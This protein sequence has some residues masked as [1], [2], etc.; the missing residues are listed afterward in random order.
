MAD[1]AEKPGASQLRH[2]FVIVRPNCLNPDEYSMPAY[3]S[4]V[5]EWRRRVALAELRTGTHW[6]LESMDRLNGRA[7]QPADQ[8]FCPH[9]AAVGLPGRVEHTSHMIF[10]CTLY[11]D[12]RALHPSLFP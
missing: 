10:E 12:L 3:L 11:N 8:R 9:C 2:Y 5:R 7:R 1:A 4:E 6:G